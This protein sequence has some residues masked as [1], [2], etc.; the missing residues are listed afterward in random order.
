[1]KITLSRVAVS[2][3]SMSALFITTAAVANKQP[4][5]ITDVRFAD[6]NDSAKI[7]VVGTN[8][9]NGAAPPVVTLDGDP[10]DVL[11]ASASVIQA[12]IP[13]NLADGDYTIAVS[14]GPGHKQN[15]DHEFRVSG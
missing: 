11:G 6:L 5:R 14:T 4:L 3:L 7:E 2:M 10:I 12:E 13:W 8:F 1:M 9:D 15:A